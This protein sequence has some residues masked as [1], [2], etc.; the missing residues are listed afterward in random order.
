[1]Q[2]TRGTLFY[3]L[4]ESIDILNISKSN[5]F[6]NCQAWGIR[7]QAGSAMGF[8]SGITWNDDNE[9]TEENL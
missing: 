3:G 6:H 7:R 4:I 8:E 2:E 1:M 5:L 9:S